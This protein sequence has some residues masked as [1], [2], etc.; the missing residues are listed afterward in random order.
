MFVFS[1]LPLV[2][3]VYIQSA[4]GSLP[5]NTTRICGITDRVYSG[6]YTLN[7][8]LWGLLK[9]D[10]LPTGYQCSVSKAT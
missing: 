3:A 8:N 6:D 9:S 4:T 7:N 1:I 5:G 10:T 2:L